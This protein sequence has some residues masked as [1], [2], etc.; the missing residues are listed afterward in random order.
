M[1]IKVQKLNPSEKYA[2]SVN[3]VKSIFGN[4]N[5]YVSFGSLS[6]TFKFDSSDHVKPQVKG[7]I[8]ASG[9]MNKRENI[10]F[11]SGGHIC[12][13][14]IKDLDYNLKKQKEFSK[15]CLPLLYTWYQEIKST[16][17]TSLHGVET[18]LIEWFNLD[19]KIHRYR[20]H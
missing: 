18:F 20:Y 9:S 5:V 4:E 11:E 12:F 17:E 13:Y 14:A 1:K 8:I 7:L 10:D 16:T 19:F 15:I 2:C 6:K 3:D